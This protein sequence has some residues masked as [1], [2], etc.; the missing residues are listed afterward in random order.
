MNMYI[1]NHIIGTTY[2]IGIIN[3]AL[4]FYQ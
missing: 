4:L 3:P 1:L 2:N